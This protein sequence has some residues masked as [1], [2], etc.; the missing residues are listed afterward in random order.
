VLAIF[1]IFDPF[2]IHFFTRETVDKQTIITIEL[3]T[4]GGTEG[5][6][7]DSGDLRSTGGTDEGVRLL[8]R[9]GWEICD[10]TRFI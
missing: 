7:P 6:V 4:T 5:R 8:D 1:G 10:R 9:R 3:K 2:F